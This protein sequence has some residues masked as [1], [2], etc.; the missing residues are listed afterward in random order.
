[1]SNA[2]RTNRKYGKIT[3]DGIAKSNFQKEKTMTATLRQ[4]IEIVAYYQGKQANDSLTDSIYSNDEFGFGEQEFAST[5]TRVCFLNIPEGE[6]EENLLAKLEKATKARIWKCL[7]NHPIL[8]T[9]QTNSITRGLKTMDEYANKQV[10]RY[11]EGHA[12]AGEIIVRNGK[13]EYKIQRLSAIGKPDEDFRNST[14]GDFYVSDDIRTELA[15]GVEEF[16]GAEYHELEDNAVQTEENEL[17]E[18]V[19]TSVGEQVM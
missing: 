2:L 9:Q 12:M 5:E 11:P 8:S 6:T 13:V 14:P 3:V 16:A 7:S 17:V 4:I 1:M 15:G 19:D 18:T 10:I